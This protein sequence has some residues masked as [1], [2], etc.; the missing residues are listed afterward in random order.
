MQ[1]SAVPKPRSGHT[2]T[3]INGSNYIMYGGIEDADQGNK[4]QPTSDIY[5]MKIAQSKSKP[6]L[7]LNFIQRADLELECSIKT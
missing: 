6:A 3:F 5:S 4:I 1:K 7:N 2:L